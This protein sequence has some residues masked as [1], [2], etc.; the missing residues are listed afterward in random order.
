MQKEH[1]IGRRVYTTV[2]EVVLY[3]AE[4]ELESRTVSVVGNYNDKERL[5]AKIA[6]ML[7]TSQVIVRTMETTSKF[8]SMSMDDFIKHADKITD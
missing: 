3:N 6:R 2:C 1:R 8:Y 5:S 7:G 4:N